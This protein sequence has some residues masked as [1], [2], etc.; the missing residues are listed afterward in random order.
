M[1]N[2]TLLT[3]PINWNNIEDPMDL[4]IWN[5]LVAN[6]W[7]PEKIALSNDL[8]SWA[9]LTPDEQMLTMRVFAGLTMLDTIQGSVGAISL[10][11]DSVTQ[12]EAAV[13]SNISFMECFTAAHDVLTADGWRSVD[14]ITRDDVVAQFNPDAGTIDFV[15]PVMVSS[16]GAESTYLLNTREGSVRQ[17]VSPGHRVLI[18]RR[19]GPD[20]DVWVPEVIAA[21]D[22]RPT[23][24]CASTRFVHTAPTGTPGGGLSVDD[25]AVIGKVEAGDDQ[26]TRQWNVAGRSQQW[27]QDFINELPAETPCGAGY[28]VRVYSTADVEN[29]DFV[30][31]A[32]TLAGYRT[33]RRD[34]AAGGHT[35]TIGTEHP[36]TNGQAVTV[37]QLPGEMVY[38]I[39]VPSTFLITRNGPSVV[40][41]GNCIHAKSYSSIFSTLADTKTINELFRWVGEDEFL[42]RKAEIVLDNY[43]GDD[44]E[45]KK[46]AS[47]L[48]ESFL[49]FSGF[50]LPM[51]WAS[52]GKLV[53]TASII[54]LILRDESLHGFYLGHKFQVAEAKA[55]PERRAELKAFAFDLLM[56]LYENEERYTESLYDGIGWTEEVKTFLR[57][58]GNK[59][60]MNLGYDPLFPGDTCQVSPSILAA[61]ATGGGEN[62]DFFSSASTSYQQGITEATSDDDWEF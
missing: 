44:P 15:H 23:D 45:R 54:K 40:I 33:V 39:Q 28:H 14:E 20:S 4:E 58:Q 5:R 29:A 55:T 46:I 53:E 19:S 11:P 35:V 26:Y 13:L 37:E 52:R 18:E 36:Y 34:Q 6:F 56:E 62:F 10:I 17:H 57:Y 31:A 27:C 22:L 59:A 32:A 38:G 43:Y 49:F 30:Q 61:I 1:R 60:L 42:Q 12:H 3:R 41:T 47:V 16:H 2:Q 25:M 9:T 24:L 48:L 50:F 51:A 7:V 21:K 8:K